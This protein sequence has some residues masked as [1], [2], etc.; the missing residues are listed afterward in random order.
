MV[1]KI[2]QTTDLV[3]W[4]GIPRGSIKT[5][6]KTDVGGTRPR[7]SV[8]SGGGAA[9]S[10]ARPVRG[11]E[12]HEYEKVV[13]MQR[14]LGDLSTGLTKDLDSVVKVVLSK[15]DNLNAETVSKDVSSAARDV[16][17]TAKTTAS[18]GQY[19]GKWGPSTNGSL[20]VAN[21]L[22][23]YVGGQPLDAS[24]NSYRAVPAATVAQ[25][26]EENSKNLITLFK[27]LGL[28]LPGYVGIEGTDFDFIIP[29]INAENVNPLLDQAS[30]ERMPVRQSE[31]SDLFRFYVL[32]ESIG[33]DKG[34]PVFGKGAEDHSQK[35]QK[36]ASLVRD[37]LI[38]RAQEAPGKSGAEVVPMYV[39][40]WKDKSQ[41]GKRNI[42][43]AD[44]DRAIWWFSR[45][46]KLWDTTIKTL[47]AREDEHPV[48]GR[49]PTA[50][51]LAVARAYDAAMQNLARQWSI[52]KAKA[53]ADK[54]AETTLVS[55]HDFGAD[56]GNVGGT[57]GRGE[58]GG[59]GGV[60]GKGY[61]SVYV[62][63]GIEIPNEVVA[64][65]FPS[66][67]SKTIDLKFLTR[68]FD[69]SQAPWFEQN[70][71]SSRLSKRDLLRHPNDVYK[72]F[73]PQNSKLTPGQFWAQFMN[74]AS[75]AIP[76][77]YSNWYSKIVNYD[78]RLQLDPEALK[79]FEYQKREASDWLQKIQRHLQMI[80]RWM[81]QS[82]S[83]AH[84]KGV[85]T[86]QE[87]GRTRERA[88][89]PNQTFIINPPATEVPTKTVEKKKY[90]RSG[91]PRKVKRREV[92]T[93]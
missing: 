40:P 53:Y 52:V 29:A 86:G 82:G 42:T 46:A 49:V 87:V 28:T 80:D 17:I 41:K 31:L 77:I 12:P 93:R 58:A 74:A 6:K 15:N 76:E 19:D 81:Q 18:E 51:D 83:S 32:L 8:P 57:R 65:P 16:G 26:A 39:D 24:I 50:R 70:S 21:K 22:V 63:N 37:S 2:A 35:L 36:I 88:S 66:G 3:E 85:P 48:L 34:I 10:G 30:A 14:L 90:R 69:S 38:V 78:N 62:I 89:R 59:A 75:I 79:L 68:H 13:R 20:K 44:M 64:V 71:N 91:L 92:P 45:R 61:S 27:D 84:S 33:I 11:T 73:M 56:G 55:T 9:A 23:A 47:Q 67:G 1:K 43:V 60:G 54:D 7:G 72:M 5:T 25:K 4:V